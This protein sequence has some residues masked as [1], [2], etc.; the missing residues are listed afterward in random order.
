[1]QSEGQTSMSRVPYVFN[2]GIR[3]MSPCAARVRAAVRPRAKDS[4]A[5]RQK[6]SA[7]RG[8]FWPPDI[9]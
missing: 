7:R 8:L 5:P 2:C 3:A 9:L 6:V 4:S 1:M